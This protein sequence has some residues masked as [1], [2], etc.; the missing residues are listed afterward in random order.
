MPELE[1]EKRLKAALCGDRAPEDGEHL[2]RRYQHAKE[3]LFRDVLPYITAVEPNLTDH[4]SRH[5]ENVL[6]NACRLIEHEEVDELDL[7]LLCQSI[8]FHDAG[9][10]RGRKDHHK[11]VGQAY[12]YAFQGTEKDP[13]ER[14]LITR[15]AAAHT[16]TAADGSTDTL[17]ELGTTEQY[18]GRVVRSQ[19]IAATLRLA[20][21]LAEGPQRTSAFAIEY[22]L[23]DRLSHQFHI[24]AGATRVTIDK[25]NKRIAVDYHIDSR[26]NSDVLEISSS[27]LSRTCF[28]SF[29]PVSM[30]WMM[31]GD[32]Q[33]TT[34]NGL[35]HSNH[36]PSEHTCRATTIPS[37]LTA[38]LSR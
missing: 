19:D 34:A 5:I 18:R 37:K 26:L 16:G 20:D 22:G 3:K 24:Y 12:D 32:T 8:L 9:N 15:I 10:F 14:R 17:Q 2:F 33:S 29:T 31:S 23:I 4:S 21:E 28:S 25:R 6:S 13:Q 30:R 36:S 7:Y 35:E 1:I 38:F 27:I 11:R